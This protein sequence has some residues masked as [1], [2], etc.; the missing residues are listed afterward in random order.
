MSKVVE[1]LTQHIYAAK[2]PEMEELDKKYEAAEKKYSFPPKRRYRLFAGGDNTN[3]LVIEREWECLADMEAAYEKAF[4][5]PEWQA[6]NSEA[7][8]IIADNQIEILLP[9]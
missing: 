3:T 7:S 9:L 8:L 6:A 2:W 5:D 4:F 1:R